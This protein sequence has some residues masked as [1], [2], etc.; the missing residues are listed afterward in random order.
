LKRIKVVLL[1]PDTQEPVDHWFSTPTSYI[2][3]LMAELGVD[4]NVAATIDVDRIA[5]IADSDLVEL[6]PADRKKVR[7]L[8]DRVA[9]MSEGELAAE[10]LNRKQSKLNGLRLTNAMLAAFL[11]MN[12]PEGNDGMP[13]KVW[14]RKQAAD[15]IPFSEFNAVTVALEELV[16]DAM[17]GGDAG[18]AKEQAATS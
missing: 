5:K 17:R 13:V 11:T 15:I 14:S 9:A 2:L 16:D 3:E 18:K 4:F 8:R 10:R 1:D 6:K 7:A 12:E